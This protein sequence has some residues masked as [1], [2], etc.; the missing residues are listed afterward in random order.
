MKYDKE[1]L[2]LKAGSTVKIVFSNPDH[3]QHNLLILAPGSL[4]KV[5]AAADKLATNP[6]AGDKDYIPQLPEML[7]ATPLVD[8]QESYDLVSRVTETPG[9]YHFVSP[10]PGHWKLM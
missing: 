6:K 10:F 1:H 3:M 5:G 9:A 8:P 2:R 4:Q 7:F